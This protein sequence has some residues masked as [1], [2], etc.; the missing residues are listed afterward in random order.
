M[1]NITVEFIQ[2]LEYNLIIVEKCDVHS[3]SVCDEDELERDLRV[4][5]RRRRIF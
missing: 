3:A 2:T 4:S 5:W 1:L